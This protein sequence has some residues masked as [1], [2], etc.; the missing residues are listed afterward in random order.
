MEK[1]YKGMNGKEQCRNI[2]TSINAKTL[3]C[4]CKFPQFVGTQN[5]Q[6]TKKNQSDFA[7][8]R[9]S[10][11]SYTEYVHSLAQAVQTVYPCEKDD[12]SVMN[13]IPIFLPLKY[14]TEHV[15]IEVSEISC[16]V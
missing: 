7:V 4:F 1:P 13:H 5:K 15:S 3:A 9:D 6:T 10:L 16:N 11:M 8:R 14:A 12:I 2:K